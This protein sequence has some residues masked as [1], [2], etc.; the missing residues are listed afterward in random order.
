MVKKINQ[1]YEGK[2]T[3]TAVERMIKG[4]EDSIIHPNGISVCFLHPLMNVEW[5]TIVESS[6]F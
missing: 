4:E 6:S 3:V 2:E 5:E 1:W